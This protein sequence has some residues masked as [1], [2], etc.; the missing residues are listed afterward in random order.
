M[1]SESKLADFHKHM[2]FYIP[3]VIR[4][5]KYWKLPLSLPIKAKKTK[6]DKNP[7]LTV[8]IPL[9]EY[10]IYQVYH[11]LILSSF[12]YDFRPFFP[13]EFD[14]YIN[15]YRMRFLLFLTNF[16]TINLTVKVNIR[17]KDWNIHICAN[18]NPENKLIS[19]QNSEFYRKIAM[20][21]YGVGRIFYNCQID[22][23]DKN[24]NLV[25]RK[26]NLFKKE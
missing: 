10:Q 8:P 22:F 7:S 24:E 4:D 20:K 2:E 13:Y 15:G 3:H 9:N 21:W 11:N 16:R 14:T 23:P 19:V 25:K 12:F 26:K 17:K 5:C 18:F 1:N 6:N